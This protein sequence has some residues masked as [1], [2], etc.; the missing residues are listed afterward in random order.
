MDTNTIIKTLRNVYSISVSTI[1]LLRDGGDN[2]LW[3]VVD[4]QD[5]KYAVRVSKREMG[6]DI[7]FESE[8]IHIL[9]NAGVSVAPIIFTKDNQPYTVMT[10]GQAVTIF[11]F[12]QGYHLMS[13]VES[14]IP[15]DAVGA[16][17][18]ALAKLHNISF[19]HSVE[20]SRKRTI[21]SELER[22]IEHKDLVIEKIPNGA[23]FVAEVEAQLLWG[24]AQSY[25]L[26][27]VHNDYRTV[28]V[29]FDGQNNVVAI[30][31]FDWS[32]IG[33]AIKDVAHALAEWSFPDGAEKHNQAI[34]S[35][36]LERYNE[37][38][39]HP[40][41][42]DTILYNWISLSCLSDACTFI[43][44]RLLRDDIREP[45]TSYMY[46]KSQYFQSLNR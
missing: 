27:L 7:A 29:M 46:K 26:A 14:S 5:K 22:V 42:E 6:D 1:E 39:T 24:K 36:F 3:T 37:Q 45:V 17:G 10:N 11:L 23:D 19:M 25:Q 34:F 40:V 35:T 32:C 16:A 43:I 33:P 38:S 9:Y 18:T 20:V 13:S 4:E 12:L 15:L 21:F 41:P 30:I 2:T 8:W 31:D 44:D 28:N